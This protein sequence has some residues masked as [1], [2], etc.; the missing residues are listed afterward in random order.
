MKMYARIDVDG[1]LVMPIRT[2]NKACD[3]QTP[4]HLDKEG[5][6]KK[7]HEDHFAKKIFGNDNFALVTF[8]DGVPLGCYT[9]FEKVNHCFFTGKIIEGVAEIDQTTLDLQAA[10]NTTKEEWRM[11]DSWFVQVRD[12]IDVTDK[13]NWKIAEEKVAI[14]QTPTDMEFKEYDPTFKFD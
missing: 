10:E 3:K 12:Q 14:G 7:P 5:E 2:V 1:N 11:R 6:I 13:A 8:A 4:C 9:D